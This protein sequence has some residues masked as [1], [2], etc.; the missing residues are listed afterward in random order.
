[1]IYIYDVRSNPWIVIKDWHAHKAP[2]VDMQL[3]VAGLWRVERLQVASLSGEGQIIA[4]DGLM[5]E[6]WIGKHVK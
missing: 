3:V 5:Y 6:D 4:W 2:I 1:M